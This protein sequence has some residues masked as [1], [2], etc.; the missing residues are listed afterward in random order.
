MTCDRIVVVYVVY[1]H[2]VRIRAVDFSV[3][4]MHES[5]SKKH[6]TTSNCIVPQVHNILIRVFNPS[7]TPSLS[8]SN[9][10]EGCE[11]RESLVHIVCACANF[12]QIG[13]I[14]KL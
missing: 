11:E 5:E 6:S 10:G 2:Y 12:T 4:C 9:C 1:S 7:L 3:K 8:H 14:R 13:V